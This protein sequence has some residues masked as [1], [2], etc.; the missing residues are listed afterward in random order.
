MAK[1]LTIRIKAFETVLEDFHDTFKNLL[2]LLHA[3]REKRPQ[4]MYQLTK[5]L[6]RDPREVKE[7][8]QILAQLDPV[9]TRHLSERWLGD[10]VQGSENVQSMRCT[11]R[12]DAMHGWVGGC[13]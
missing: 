4:S 8:L 12:Y 1:T 11:H 13:G 7:D 10:C 3:I 9:A 5:L 2:H 6:G